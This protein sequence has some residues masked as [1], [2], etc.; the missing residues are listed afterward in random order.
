MDYKTLIEKKLGSAES[1]N[2]IIHATVDGKTKTF[3]VRGAASEAEAKKKFEQHHAT[4]PIVKV[5]KEE[6]EL[7]EDHLKKGTKIKDGKEEL[8]IEKPVGK[9]KYLVKAKEPVE[10]EQIDEI[11]MEVAGKV[12]SKRRNQADTDPSKK[13]KAD[14]AQQSFHK[15]MFRDIYKGK[16]QADINKGYASDADANTK[17]GWSNESVEMKQIEEQKH[18]VAVTVSEPD[19]PAISMRKATKQRFIRVSADSAKNAVERAKSYYKKSGYKVHGAEYVSLINEDSTQVEEQ[20]KNPFDWKGYIEQRKKQGGTTSGGT[21]TFHD[22]KKTETGTRYTR[23][24]DSDGA[25][26]YPD[27]EG[28]VEAPKRGRGRPPGKYGSYKE[29]SA[30]TNAAAKAKQAATRAANK[31]KLKESFTED[32]WAE[33]VEDFT[34]EQ[35]FVD[36]QDLLQCEEFEQLDELSKKTLN[37]YLKKITDD[38]GYIVPGRQTGATKAAYRTQGLSHKP[39]TEGMMKKYKTESTEEVEQSLEESTISKYADFLSRTK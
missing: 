5:V 20:M 7:E 39:G 14:R 17:R 22:V 11:S 33:L 30:E 9:D 28:T 37:S 24:T 31:A 18:R 34:T 10:E 21:R 25:S 16:S 3:R 29:R 1:S 36:F 35:E 26:K 12:A 4:T 13:A 27:V 8:T 23:Q 19:H 38:E 6:V 2:Y 32:D 15:R